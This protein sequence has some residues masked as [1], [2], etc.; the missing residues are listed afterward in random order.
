MKDAFKK[1][2]KGPLKV[3]YMFGRISKKY[4]LLNRLI[5]FG[6]DRAWRRYLIRIAQIPDKGSVLD[7]GA[8]TGDIAIEMKKR[9]PLL[10]VV[11]ADI[12]YEM[13]A[14]GKKRRSGAEIEWCQA[15]ALKLPFPDA[16]FDAVTSGFLARNVP[17]ME[18]MF[19]EQVRVLKPGGRLV[20]LDTSPVPD[21]FFKPLILF[22]YRV[23][24]PLMGSLISG[25][26]DAYRYL[27]ETTIKFIR[28]ETLANKLREAG[29]IDVNFKRFMFGNIAVHWGI[30]PDVVELRCK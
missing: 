19:R 21:N 27:P 9:E 15:D 23:I 3:R 4:D 17:D 16:M 14:V 7:T 20:C 25:E 5:S 13:M 28:P 18:A 10:R 26:M 22:Y 11:A 8:G 1:P 24:I 2:D 12:T 6:F 29:L 30:R